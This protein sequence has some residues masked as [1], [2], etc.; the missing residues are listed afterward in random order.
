MLLYYLL[1]LTLPL[2]DQRYLAHPFLGFTAEKWLGLA[3]FAYALFDWAMHR[4]RAALMASAQVR[5]F[6]V[7]FLLALLSYCTIAARGPGSMMLVYTSNLLFLVTTVILVRTV[8]RLRW[9][10]L[11][12]T[13]SMALASVYMIRDWLAGSAVYGAG[14][15]PGYVAGDPNYFTASVLVILPFAFCVLAER[16]SRLLRL[17]CLAA[18][19]LT[20]WAVMLTASRGGFLGLVAAGLYLIA[21]SRH[22][23]RNFAGAT[24]L[25]AL[26]L[27]FAPKTPLQRLLHPTSGD[28]QSSHDRLILWGAGLRMV[29]AHPMAGI[30]L[31]NFKPE[32]PRYTSPGTTIDFI[33]HN[34]YIEIAAA[35]GLPGILAFLAILFFTFRSLRRSRRLARPLDAEWI[36]LAA[37]GLETGMVGFCLAIFFLSAAFLKLLWFAVFISAVLPPLLAQT[38]AVPEEEAE[39]ALVPDPAA[40]A[41]WPVAADIAGPWDEGDPWSWATQAFQAEPEA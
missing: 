24:V 19:G 20:L 13:A 34:T 1:I 21:R 39:A 36:Y 32:L 23:W 10:L 15:R 4:R 12:A 14:Y 22:R 17:Y 35:M 18:L 8:E 28:R 41:Y 37:S 38:A 33:A 11:A 40:A 25:L 31:D 16:R 2:M 27:A 6:L 9:T 5:T 29:A 26:A 3:C 30:G 7:F